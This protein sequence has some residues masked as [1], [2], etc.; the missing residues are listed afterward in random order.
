MGNSGFS[1]LKMIFEAYFFKK[2]FIRGFKN[3]FVFQGSF[4]LS[5][6]ADNLPSLNQ[7]LAVLLSPWP[8]GLKQKVRSSSHPS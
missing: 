6:F 5:G 7:C 2:D 8:S 4:G 1:G 3:L